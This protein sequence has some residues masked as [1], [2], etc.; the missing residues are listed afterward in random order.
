[1]YLYASATASAFSLGT[2]ANTASLSASS[3]GGS[4]PRVSFFGASKTVA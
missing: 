4:N 3:D 1:M 2:I